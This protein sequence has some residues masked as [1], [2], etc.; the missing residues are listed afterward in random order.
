MDTHAA[1]ILGLWIYAASCEHGKNTVRARAVFG[2][3]VFFS[4]YFAAL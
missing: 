2:V 3:A 4:A 1:I